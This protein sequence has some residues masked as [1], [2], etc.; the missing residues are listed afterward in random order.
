MTKFEKFVKLLDGADVTE[1]DDYPVY[2]DIVFD[3][4]S[5]VSLE[6]EGAD[7]AITKEEIEDAVEIS[8]SKFNILVGEKKVPYVVAFFLKIPYVLSE[9]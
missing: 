5:G 8:E 9:N 4:D 3:D 1:V 7:V 2:F 6:F